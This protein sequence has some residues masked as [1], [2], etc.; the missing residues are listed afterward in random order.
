MSIQELVLQLSLLLQQKQLMI[1]SV[2]S[3][4]G[5][6]LASFF[7]DLPGSSAWFE[8][9]FVT[10]SNLAKEEMLA[11]P[12]QLIIEKG[13][14]SKEVAEA[15]AKGALKHS[16]ASISVAIT[17]IAGPDGGSEQKPVGTVWFAYAYHKKLKSEVCLFANQSRQEVRMK[18]SEQALRGLI[19]FLAE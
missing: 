3:C 15:M 18:A 1:A 10:Y 16:K 7:T 11:V 2:E 8:R 5:G 12:K 19:R 4:T 14:V 17:G 13:A 6:L 9:G